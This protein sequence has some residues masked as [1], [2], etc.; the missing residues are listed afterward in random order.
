MKRFVLVAVVAGFAVSATRVDAVPIYFTDRTA[1]DAAAG[2]GL[3]FEG[4]EGAWTD[5]GGVATFTD[6][7]LS[8]T[9]GIN[10]LFHATEAGGGINN[11][12]LRYR[13]N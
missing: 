7:S 9:G 13:G 1:F 4:F 12:V 6:F 11:L 10:N 2:G 5:T 3:S 8:E